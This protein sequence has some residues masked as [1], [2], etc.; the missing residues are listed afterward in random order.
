MTSNKEA[1]SNSPQINANSTA[2]KDIYKRPSFME[3]LEYNGSGHKNGSKL[4]RLLLS[5]KKL[6]DAERLECVRT[7]GRMSLEAC[8]ELLTNEFKFYVKNPSS[9][10][11]SAKN[12]ARRL[13]GMDK[14]ASDLEIHSTAAFSCVFLGAE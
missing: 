14:M 13:S 1:V 3:K 2:K 9:L 12:N 6:L 7:Y 4:A 5:D 8:T 10:S 11:I